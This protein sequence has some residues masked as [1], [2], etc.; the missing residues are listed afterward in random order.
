[1][2]DEQPVTTE[3]RKRPDYVLNV[4]MDRQFYDRLTRT[5][6]KRRTSRAGLARQALLEKMEAAGE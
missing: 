6:Q 1:M 2:P 3:K 5:A 4:P